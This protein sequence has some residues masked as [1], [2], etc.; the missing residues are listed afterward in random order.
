M[1]TARHLSYAGQLERRDTDS[2]DLVVIHCTELPD[3]AKAREYGEVIHYPDSGTGNSGHF[4]IDRDG[5]CEE[6]VPVD[7]IAHHVRGHNATS[8]GIELV[9]RGRYPDWFDTRRQD[10]FEPYP[11]VQIKGLLALLDQLRAAYP[12]LIYITGHDTLDQDRVPASNQP[13]QT[14]RRK[15]D[16]GPGFPWSRVIADSGLVRWR[17]RKGNP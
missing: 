9:N 1:I 6:W 16:P 14:V 15:L 3:L 5:H 17:E 4:Y 13:W 8:V 10:D 7:R 11:E 2:I 12:S